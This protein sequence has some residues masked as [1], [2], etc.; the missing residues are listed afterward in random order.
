MTLQVYIV[1]HRLL[2]YSQR[3]FFQTRS[4]THPNEL[5]NLKFIHWSLLLLDWSSCNRV[6]CWFV[7][8]IKY[9]CIDIKMIKEV[10]LDIWEMCMKTRPQITWWHI[11][12]QKVL[13][14]YILHHKLDISGLK[15]WIRQK[16]LFLCGIAVFFCRVLYEGEKAITF[17][18]CK[19]N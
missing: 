11:T 10:T 12:Q 6:I 13:K 14:S 19:L 8:E 4:T 9:W 15:L 16:Q 7:N 18:V 1:S 2:P 17:C 3:F 5:F